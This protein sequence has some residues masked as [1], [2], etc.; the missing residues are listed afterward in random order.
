MRLS[1]RQAEPPHSTRGWTVMRFSPHIFKSCNRTRRRSNGDEHENS[2]YHRALSAWADLYSLRP[3]RLSQ[4]HSSTTADEPAC[5]SVLRC[6]QC[7]TLRRV[8]LR[9]PVDWRA[10][11]AFGLLC[12]ARSYAAC[13][14]AIQ[15]PR[16]SSDAC[17]GEHCSGT[18]SLCSVG[19]GLPA[20][21]RQLQRCSSCEARGAGIVGF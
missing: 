14:R 19:L 6:H 12:T 5:D 13:G 16:V 15:H 18:G 21:S 2:F 7:L 20:I 3:E 10:A 17:A 4:L 8:L 1:S 11:V 9:S